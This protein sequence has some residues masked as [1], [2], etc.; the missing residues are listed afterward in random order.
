MVWFVF[1]CGLCIVVC[2]VRFMICVW[3]LSIVVCCLLV[4]GL[5]FGVR[6]ALFVFR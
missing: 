6:F 3:W 1:D 2:D 5:R 4:V